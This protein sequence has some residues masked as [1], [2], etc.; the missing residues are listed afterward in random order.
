[1]TVE[2]LVN[3]PWAKNTD[4]VRETL[5]YYLRDSTNPTP[6]QHLQL[7]RHHGMVNT[8]ARFSV[9]LN[10]KMK[11]VMEMLKSHTGVTLVYQYRYYGSEKTAVVWSL[12]H[13]DRLP[14]KIEMIL[15]T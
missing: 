15:A 9:V 2:L 14:K 1:M 6:V 7:T 5:N 10:N 11:S 3:C 8:T 4:E 12:H 13:L